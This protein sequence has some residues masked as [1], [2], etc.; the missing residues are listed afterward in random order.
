MNLSD[1]PPPSHPE[2]SRPLQSHRALPGVIK[3]SHG[4]ILF[5]LS[6]SNYILYWDYIIFAMEKITFLISEGKIN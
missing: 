4:G 6:F 1:C 5:F 3:H 2:H